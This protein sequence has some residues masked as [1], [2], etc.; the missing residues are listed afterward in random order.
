MATKPPTKRPAT[1]A[2]RRRRSGRTRALISL[3]A[4]AVMATGLSVKGTFA[5]WTDSASVQTG[6]FTSGTLDVTLSGNL[7]GA[8]NNGGT[9]NN[10]SFAL[11]EMVP[12]ESIA[13]SF[14]VRNNGSVPL[15]YTVAGTGAGGL[16][17]TNGLQYSVA[18][19]VNAAN[20][21][22]QAGGNRAGACGGTA[23]SDANTTLLTSTS[24]SL[25]TTRTLAVGTQETVCIV[26]RFNSNAGNGLQGLSGSA[27]L[28]FDAKQI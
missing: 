26:A 22:S 23:S 3:A 11:A 15:S 12:G 16:A 19:G 14:P 17:V 21:G 27:S 4:V 18:F 24:T 6:S 5:F 13:V 25:A 7:A 10:T 2:S 1:S 8:A 28:L 20:S 9:W